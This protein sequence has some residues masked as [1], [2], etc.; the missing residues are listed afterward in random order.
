MTSVAHYSVIYPRTRIVSLSLCFKEICS[1]KDN[2]YVFHQDV[3]LYG[4]T[5]NL[6]SLVLMTETLIIIH[7][8]MAL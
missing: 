5:L 3:L 8:S 6:V 7:S 4:S 2:I 1:C